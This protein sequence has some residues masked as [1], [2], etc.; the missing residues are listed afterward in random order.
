[1]PRYQHG[2]GKY[3]PCCGGHCLLASVGDDNF[4]RVS[5]MLILAP[6]VLWSL[7]AVP[8]LWGLSPV[9]PIVGALLFVSSVSFLVA[10]RCTEPGILPNQVV[11]GVTTAGGFQK[12]VLVVDDKRLELPERRAKYV[13]ETEVV[14]EKFDQ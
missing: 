12:K 5:F 6:T 2:A 3:E 13:R 11:E 10:A 9:L 4:A 7:F 14:V 1:M 8:Y